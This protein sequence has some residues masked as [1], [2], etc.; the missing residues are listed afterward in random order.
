MDLQNPHRKRRRIESAQGRSRL[1][2]ADRRMSGGNFSSVQRNFASRH[3][4]PSSQEVSAMLE[5]IGTPSLDALVEKTVPHS[6]RLKKPMDLPPE[7]SEEEALAA[8]RGVASENE[9]F[10]SY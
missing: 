9:I 3:I 10:R 4:G 6:I 7:L 8:L 2:G 1:P 5:V